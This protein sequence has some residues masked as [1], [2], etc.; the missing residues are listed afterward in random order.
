MDSEAVRLRPL[1]FRRGVSLAP[2]ILGKQL[3]PHDKQIKNEY[4][5]ILVFHPLVIL[6]YRGGKYCKFYIL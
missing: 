4:S 6:V 2:E 3:D 5:Q 1:L